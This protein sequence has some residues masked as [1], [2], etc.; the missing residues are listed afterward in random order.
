M[1]PISL[2]AQQK[3]WGVL[4]KHT[5]SHTASIDM[6]TYCPK[7]TTFY[8]AMQTHVEV[9]FILFSRLLN[10]MHAHAFVLTS[11]MTFPHF[12]SGMNTFSQQRGDIWSG[13]M[14]SQQLKHWRRQEM[15]D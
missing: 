5:C 14:S 11:G 15:H 6:N 10:H 4:K 7:Y 3:H 13:L 9:L 1:H 12:I 2:P 8:N